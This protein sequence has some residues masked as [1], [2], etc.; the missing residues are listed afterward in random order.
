MTSSPVLDSVVYYLT[1]GPAAA[2]AC[3]A[4]VHAVRRTGIHNGDI[5]CSF[6]QHGP[7]G[8]LPDI[9]SFQVKLKKKMPTLLEDMVL[10]VCVFFKK[11][12]LIQ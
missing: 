11:T 10:C 9:S 5:C 1:F 7:G 6:L 12:N 4:S 3:A 8:H 2:Q